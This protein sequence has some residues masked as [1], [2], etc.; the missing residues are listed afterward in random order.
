MIKD[1]IEDKKRHQQDDAINKKRAFQIKD[2]EVKECFVEDIQSED[3]VVVYDNEE[4]PADM[5]LLNCVGH[6]GCKGFCFVETS[7]LDGES[8]LKRKS[9]KIGREFCIC[10]NKKKKINNENKKPIDHLHKEENIEKNTVNQTG[11]LIQNDGTNTEQGNITPLDSTS[12]SF[13]GNT[14]NNGFNNSRVV[15]NKFIEKIENCDKEIISKIQSFEI[16]KTGDVLNDT[17]CIVY[18]A[19]DS[20]YHSDK[21]ILLKGSKLKNT[22]YVIGLVICVGTDTKQAKNQCVGGLRVSLFE[23]RVNK[24]LCLIFVAYFFIL[25]FTSMM[26]S[27]FLNK[28]D[29]GY[30]YLSSNKGYDGLVLTGTNYILFSYLIPISLFL[31]LEIGR[32]FSALFIANDSNLFKNGSSS[33]CR[34]SNVV[35]DLG[36]IEHILTDKT[37]TLTNNKMS[38]KF[39]HLKNKKGLETIEDCISN[40]RSRSMNFKIQKNLPTEYSNSEEA[41]YKINDDTTLGSNLHENDNHNEDNILPEKSQNLDSLESDESNSFIQSDLDLKDNFTLFFIG[42]LVCNSVDIFKNSYE[43]PSQDEI[44]ILN[45]IRSIGSLIKRTENNILISFRNVKQRIQIILTLDFTSKRQR[46]SVI[47][48]IKDKYILFIKGSDQVVLPL[49]KER[50]NLSSL[51]DENSYYRSLVIAYKEIKNIESIMTAYRGIDLKHRKQ[52][53]ESLFNGFENNVNYLGCT[54]VE[55]SL[56]DGICDCIESFK[57]ANIRIWMVT[58]DKKETAYSCGVMCGLIQDEKKLSRLSLRNEN[59]NTCMSKS[60]KDSKNGSVTHTL[61][62]ESKEEE[63]ILISALDIIEK[64]S[65]NE[66]IES[67]AIIFRSS[68]EQKAKIANFLVKQGLNILSIGDGSNDV[69]MLQA[70]HV[71]VGIQGTEGTHASLSSDFSIPTFSCLK[72]LL[73]VHGRYNFLRLSKLTLNSIFKNLLLI[74]IQIFFNFFNGYSGRPVFNFFFLNYFNILFTSAIPLYIAIFDKDVDEETIMQKPEKYQE[75]TKYFNSKIIFLNTMLAIFKA[76][77]IFWLSYGIFN[78]KDFTNSNGFIGG[79][80]AMNNYFSLLV[81]IAVFVRQ[82]RLISY[83][84][85]FSYFFILLSIVLYFITIFGIQEFS[86]TTK[87]S[88]FHLYSIP[89]FYFALMA[90]MGLTLLFDFVYDTQHNN[91]I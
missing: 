71:S 58:G 91:C 87:N 77:V 47:V 27:L 10:N 46:M 50:K 45:G 25:F 51:I 20:F 67:D 38:L 62:L 16:H 18:T 44:C 4:I 79:Y 2:D 63:C 1:A 75:T 83:F 12:D 24:S 11:N 60:K 66:K 13:E 23:K 41:E 64:L 53:L 72:R 86:S 52:K 49:I 88:A 57:K 59:K 54:F 15:E 78:V 55:D 65:K 9:A 84:N 5:I 42:L 19:D 6:N 76:S 31:T 90:V 43:G 17:Q 36:I 35:E 39:V 85:M 89:S 69:M 33:Q 14:F 8:N 82:I 40:D 70:S 28:N 22:V 3:F 48:K 81:F 61:T 80:T 32:I 29:I 37:G 68:P 21:N 26:G 34:N 7:N 30:F 74:F 56:Q 73:F